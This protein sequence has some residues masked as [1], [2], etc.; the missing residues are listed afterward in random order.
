MD[1]FGFDHLAKSL[2]SP[3]TRRATLGLF[4][5]GLLGLTAISEDASAKK[6]KKKHKK[7]KQKHK[8]NG[9]QPSGQPSGQAPTQEQCQV[10]DERC[11]PANPQLLRWPAMRSN[12]HQRHC[13]DFLLRAGGDC[14][15]HFRILLLRHV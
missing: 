1:H 12:G 2:A 11:V 6:R 10:V 9:G 7:R 4:A 13:W 8:Q 3:A 5:T 14:L 15:H